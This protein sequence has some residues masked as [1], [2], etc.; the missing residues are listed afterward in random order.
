[1][2]GRVGLD[3]IDVGIRLYTVENGRC[4]TSNFAFMNIMLFPSIIV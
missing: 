2:L 4:R 1:V 3:H